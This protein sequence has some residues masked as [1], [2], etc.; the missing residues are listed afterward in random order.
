MGFEMVI[1]DEG[2]ILQT[3]AQN[4]TWVLMLSRVEVEKDETSQPE[5]GEQTTN[6]S[7]AFSSDSIHSIQIQFTY[8]QD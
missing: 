8:F 2:K 3:L 5:R 4:G 1:D 7:L 6:F